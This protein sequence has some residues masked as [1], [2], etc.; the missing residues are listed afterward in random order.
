MNTQRLEEI[1]RQRESL[2]D[3]LQDVLARHNEL[4]RES[5]ALACAALI[6]TASGLRDNFRT[7]YEVWAEPEGELEIVSEHDADDIVLIGF[8]G[9][10]GPGGVLSPGE[11]L[12]R[13]TI[14]RLE[15]AGHD[16]SMLEGDQ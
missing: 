5:P 15:A 2:Y 4:V 8:G 16:A 7:E 3:E 1:E 11:E 10:G 12:D 14:R 9:E 13:E 6:Q